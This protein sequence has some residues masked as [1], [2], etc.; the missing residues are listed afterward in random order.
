MKQDEIYYIPQGSPVAPSPFDVRVQT[1]NLSR[2]RITTAELKKHLAGLADD[3]AY[4][5][6]VS[7]DSVVSDESSDGASDGSSA[8]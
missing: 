8:N 3:A 2:G 4:G 7:F 1:K 5:K 6:V